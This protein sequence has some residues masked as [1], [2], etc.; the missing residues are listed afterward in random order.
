MTRSDQWNER[1]C[2]VRYRTWCDLARTAATGAPNSYL[3]P[4]QFL[5]YYAFVHH[6]IPPSWSK[7]KKAIMEGRLH[8]QKPDKDNVEK[9]INDALFLDDSPLAI[10]GVMAQYWGY[11]D[12]EPCIDIFLIPTPG[13]T[14]I[15]FLHLE[16]E[17]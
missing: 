8:Q 11:E 13:V 4:E 1:D 14:E 17:K 3:N 15:Q 9:A 12:I 2:V 6:P 16:S 7:G 5:G 10:G